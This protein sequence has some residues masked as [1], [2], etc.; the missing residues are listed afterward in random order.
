MDDRTM[1]ELAAKAAGVDWMPATTEKG[2]EL[3]PVFGLWLRI[4]GEPSEHQRRRWNPLTDDGDALRLAIDLQLGIS[5]P[6]VIDGRVDVV[7][8]YGPLISVIEFP[9]SGDRRAATRRAITRAAAEIQLA[10]ESGK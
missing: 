1:L 6:P 3:E 10:K 7:T 2:S 4:H 9:V 8:F 5:I